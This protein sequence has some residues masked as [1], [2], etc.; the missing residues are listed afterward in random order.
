MMMLFRRKE[1]VN[2]FIHDKRWGNK[3]CFRTRISSNVND[4]K[5]AIIPGVK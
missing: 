1:G 3:S 5:T 2:M 4:F